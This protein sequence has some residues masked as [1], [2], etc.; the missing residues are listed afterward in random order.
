MW[1]R[2]CRDR[3]EEFSVTS[4]LLLI[5]VR[6][7]SPSALAAFG[8][9]SQ[10]IFLSGSSRNNA[11]VYRQN[12][13]YAFDHEGILHGLPNF[14]RCL[15]S[16]FVQGVPVCRIVLPQISPGFPICACSG[17][18]RQRPRRLS[19]LFQLTP[20]PLSS[21]PQTPCACLLPVLPVL[22]DKQNRFH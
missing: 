19:E 14:L 4:T 1:R 20:A 13:S 3:I 7:Y 9:L 8:L 16:F 6:M 17:H 12:V 11:W 22:P 18:R 15:P 5:P 21:H 2:V 10:T